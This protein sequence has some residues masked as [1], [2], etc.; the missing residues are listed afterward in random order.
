MNDH[1]GLYDHIDRNPFNNVT[2]N[3]RKCTVTQNIQNRVKWVKNS[4]SKYKG[5]CWHKKCKKWSAQIGV[6]KA[7]VHLGLF[8]TEEAAALAYNKAALEHFGE[9]AHLNTFELSPTIVE[10]ESEKRQ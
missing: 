1:K 4:S 6:K 10:R 5:V 8:E 2:S 7:Q 9:F 3:L